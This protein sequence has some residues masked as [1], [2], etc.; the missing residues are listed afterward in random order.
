MATAQSPGTF[1]TSGNMTTPRGGHTATLL[2][3]GRVLIVGGFREVAFGGANLV[4]T[5]TGRYDPLTGALTPAG[6]MTTPRASHTATLL[7]DGRVLIAGCQD[8]AD[9]LTPHIGH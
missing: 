2:P 4:L 9:R 8:G 5:T 1:R 7:P 3:N 6:D